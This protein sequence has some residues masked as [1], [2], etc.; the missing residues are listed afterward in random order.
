MVDLIGFGFQLEHAGRPTKPL[1]TSAFEIFTVSTRTSIIQSPT[2]RSAR[3]SHLHTISADHPWRFCKLFSRSWSQLVSTFSADTGESYP[4]VL[5]AERWNRVRIFTESDSCVKRWA[6]RRL[7]PPPY[8]ELIDG[9]HVSRNLPDMLSERDNEE[10]V[11]EGEPHSLTPEA[12]IARSKLQLPGADSGE[13]ILQA[14]TKTIAYIHFRE[15]WHR[16]CSRSPCPYCI[17][18]SRSRCSYFCFSRGDTKIVFRAQD[19]LSRVT[20]D[21]RAVR[22]RTARWNGIAVRRLCNKLSARMV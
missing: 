10:G 7:E 16:A 17:D 18:D 11:F 19:L 8:V 14:P 22:I 20:I 9:S 6:K 1:E 15:E 3:P 5:R 2:R 13:A 12:T 21:G 4:S